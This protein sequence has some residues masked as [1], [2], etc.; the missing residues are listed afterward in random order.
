MC[1]PE[2]LDSRKNKDILQRALEFQP[3]EHYQGV[4]TFP[5]LRLDELRY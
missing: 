4:L 2:P 1:N 5:H 3:A